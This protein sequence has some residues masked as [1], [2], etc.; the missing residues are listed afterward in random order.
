[1]NQRTAPQRHAPLEVEQRFIN[2]HAAN[3]F[4]HL[5]GVATKASA[6]IQSANSVRRRPFFRDLCGTL[7]R[8]GIRTRLDTHR[9]RPAVQRSQ[10]CVQRPLHLKRTGWERRQRVTRRFRNGAYLFH[11]DRSTD[12]GGVS[13]KNVSDRLSPSATRCPYFAPAR[14]P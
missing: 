1:M 14:M 11:V 13:E 8:R 12:V 9:E 7:P 5:V 2:V 3:P 6:R 4:G 10:A